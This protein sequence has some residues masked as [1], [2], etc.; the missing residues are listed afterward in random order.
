MT[1]SG[2]TCETFLRFVL[3]FAQ[4]IESMSRAPPPTLLSPQLEPTPAPATAQPLPIMT[5]LQR[6]IQQS[7]QQ[8]HTQE[9]SPSIS[10]GSFDTAAP[11]QPFDL[12]SPGGFPGFPVGPLIAQH[13]SP[14]PLPPSPGQPHNIRLGSPQILSSPHSSHPSPATQTTPQQTNSPRASGG[15]TLQFVP[16][17]VLRKMSKKP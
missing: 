12:S 3:V 17:Q 15:S 8:F 2:H 10:N 6:A 5:M 1:R 4:A 14:Q 16:S 11:F 7:N 13:S 9:T